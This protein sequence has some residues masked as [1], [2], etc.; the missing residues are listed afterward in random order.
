MRTTCHS[1]IGRIL[2]CPWSEG[3]PHTD[4]GEGLG[5]TDLE[6]AGA[7]RINFSS[8]ESFDFFVRQSQFNY[9]PANSPSLHCDA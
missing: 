2:L 6:A 3:I 7:Q 5:L 4:R 9:P 8:V 1:L